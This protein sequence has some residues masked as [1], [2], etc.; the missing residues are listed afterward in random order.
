MRLPI[1]ILA[2][3]IVLVLLVAIYA[4]LSALRVVDGRLHA[5]Q[6]YCRLIGEA[7]TSPRPIILIPG[8]KGSLLT[9]TRTGSIVWLTLRS[10]LPGSRS[11]IYDETTSSTADT[12][13]PTGILTRL[14]IVP[15]LLA[16]EPYYRM[17]AALACRGT[18]YVYAYDWRKNP[19]DN[20]A[21]LATLVERVHT[22]TGMQPSIVAHS[23]G[24]LIT[25]LYLREHADRVHRVAY[26]GV[27]FGS[28]LSFIDDVDRGS[29]VGFNRSLLSPAAVFSHPG[30]FA[31]LPHP[32][33]LLYK[34]LDLT[35]PATWRT[36]KLSVYADNLTPTDLPFD[37]DVVLERNLTQARSFFTALD[38][39]HE[40][41]ND[42][43]F[44]VG[45][46]RDTLARITRTGERVY[47]PGDGRVLARSALPRDANV[48]HKTVLDACVTHDW[49]L[50]DRA[51]VRSIIDFID[52][53]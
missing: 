11:L 51:I 2:F 12:I 30:T 25:H 38:T 7:T 14:G 20:V 23:M 33:A 19:L 35:D 13:R 44:V 32:G 6:A 28:G 50:N 43:L 9:D 48:L 5:H 15:H 47:A 40:L 10:V 8:T 29:P 3:G 52:A 26:V 49:Q 1:L 42:L 46:C 17:S 39:P 37:R 45:S 24:G 31:L 27:P 53:P 41:P 21:G 36:E 4:R 34:D 16:Y 18:G 22:E